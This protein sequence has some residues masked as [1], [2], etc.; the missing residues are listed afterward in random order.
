MLLTLTTIC[1]ALPCPARRT[2]RWEA[3]I[4]E[5]KKQLYLGGFEEETSAAKAH[6]VMSVWTRGW[7][8]QMNL[9]PGYYRRLGQFVGVVPKV[10]LQV[11]E[12]CCMAWRL[13]SC[14]A[15]FTRPWFVA[16]AVRWRL[17]PCRAV[18]C[19]AMHESVPVCRLAAPSTASHQSYS[20]LVVQGTWRAAAA[21]L[22][23]ATP[24]PMPATRWPLH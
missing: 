6:D 23:P 17:V 13:P 12:G 18:P 3:H 4:W 14:C 8:A 2:R 16:A 24:M 10:R 22:T 5:N 9:R 7:E 19:R 21:A 20:I 15:H 11:L 1:P